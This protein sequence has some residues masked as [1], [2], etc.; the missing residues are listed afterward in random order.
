MLSDVIKHY[1][2]EHYAKHILIVAVPFRL[3]Y[4]TMFLFNYASRHTSS[5]RFF[6]L[7]LVGVLFFDML[8]HVH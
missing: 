5:R 2:L 6:M 3:L 7:Y 8:M 1:A 4:Y